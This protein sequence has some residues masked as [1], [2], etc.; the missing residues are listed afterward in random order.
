MVKH[1]DNKADSVNH[2]DRLSKPWNR[3]ALNLKM[4]AVGPTS[5]VKQ[6]VGM[7]SLG[8][9]QPVFPLLVHD[10]LRL[11]LAKTTQAQNER[12]VLPMPG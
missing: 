2:S 6:V 9:M 4:T 1:V 8:V 10:A 7:K 12:F 11:T 5:V 3:I